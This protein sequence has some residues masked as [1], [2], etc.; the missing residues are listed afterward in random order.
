[1]TLLSV[2]ALA[3]CLDSGGD[4][5]DDRS[6]GQLT[7]TG[8]EGL[9]YQTNSQSGTT[10]ARGEFRYYPGER[11]SLRVGNLA[12]YDGIPAQ[13]YVTPLE[14]SASI[15]SQLSLTSL[16]DEGLLSHKPTEQQLIESDEVMNLTRLLLALSWQPTTAEGRG[17]EIRERVIS[18]LNAALPAIGGDLDFTVS[19][20]E[21]GATEP[22]LSPAN[23]LLAQICFYPEGDELCQDPPTQAEIDN[24]PEAPQNQQDRDPDVEYRQDLE[25]KRERI[26][27]AIR[28]IEDITRDD[29]RSYLTREL[30][31][32]S[33]NRSNR[34]YL[35]AATANLAA[36]DTGIKTIQIRRVG[37][38]PALAQLEAISTNPQDLVVHSFSSQTAEV[39]YF[40]EGG[41]GR[42][43]EVLVNFRP[44][45]DYRWVR[46][47]IRVIIE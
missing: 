45:G 25:N 23:Q 30:D 3:G 11:L 2:V 35:D 12:L 40:I 47:Q 41:A 19:S 21:F 9:S 4:A 42:E 31:I 17:I 32:I 39:E 20:N 43:G 27:G 16:N 7:P 18:Q 8:I 22:T 6:T 15:R 13:D 36:S 33:N 44:A 29:V 5:S 1:M 38:E 14:F 10:N 24:A 37:A 46:K 34:Y 26:L 28:S